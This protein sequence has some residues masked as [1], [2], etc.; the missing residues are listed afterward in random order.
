MRTPFQAR[1]DG[2]LLKLQSIAGLFVFIGICWAVSSARRKIAWR[3]VVVGL[4]LQVVLGLVFLKWDHGRL[5]LQSV[6]HGVASFLELST[7]GSEFMFGLLGDR[8]TAAKLFADFPP[9]VAKGG[10]IMAFQVLPTII[11]FSAFM[12]VIYHLGVMKWVVRGIAWV[13]VRLMGTSGSE[14]LSVASNIF[15]GQTEAPLLV[16]PFLTGMTKSELMAVMTGGFATIAGGVFAL[17][18]GF[19]VDAGHLMIAS[20]M[21]APAALVVAKL[22]VPETE[23]SETMGEVKARMDKTASNV[24]EA[25]ANGTTDGLKLALNVGAML[26]AFLGL[27]AVVDW[28]LAAGSSLFTENAAHYL[29]LQKIFGVLFAPFAF[30][31]GIGPGDVGQVGQLLGYKIAVNELV[32]YQ[33]L[34]A[35][36]PELS[37][38]SATIATYA[39]CGFANFSSIA[40]QI[41]GIS[42]LA[43]GRKSDLAKLGVRAMFGGAIASWMTAC[44]A[45]AL[46]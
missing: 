46:I 10:F 4:T 14:S 38:R 41:G 18:V 44:V 34:A 9:G 27:I 39:L 45:G 43:P 3:T 40:I 11:F 26:I 6:S 17:Y 12:A 42:A 29:S 32:A 33:Q 31:L 25:A 22:L 21:S 37:A 20:V 28:L 5:F 13:M 15:V 24:V 36:K 35:M 16:R 19:G 8:A 1:T 30:F 23:E 7:T 2:H